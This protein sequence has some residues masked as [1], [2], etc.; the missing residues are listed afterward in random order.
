MR[1]FGSRTLAAVVAGTVAFSGASVAQA[2][3]SLPPQ[4]EQLSSQAEEMSSQVQ[5]Q[6]EDFRIELPPQDYDLAAKYGIELPEFLKPASSVIAGKLD[7]ATTDHLKQQGHRFDPNAERVAQDWANQA[8]A[9]KLTFE[10]N[11]AHGQTMLD[12]GTGTVLRLD[13][14]Q[15]QDR[16]A[17]L[18]RDVN[19][20][21]HPRKLNFGVASAVDGN[22]VYVAEYFFDSENPIQR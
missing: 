13:K 3:P 11:H 20:N 22:Y 6:I 14:Q 17:W 15:A 12:K 18:D 7:D 10:G 2:Q 9:D 19:V 21:E 16:L 5:K 1:N 4:V 8:A